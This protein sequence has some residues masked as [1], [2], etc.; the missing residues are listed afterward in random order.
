VCFAQL[1]KIGQIA[2]F[3]RNLS[4]HVAIINVQVLCVFEAP[5]AHVS[6]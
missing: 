2:Y 1:T 5:P 4:L 6:F 3:C